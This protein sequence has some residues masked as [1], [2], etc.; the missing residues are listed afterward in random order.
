MERLTDLEVE[1]ISSAAVKLA[2]PPA[3]SGAGPVIE[4]GCLVGRSNIRG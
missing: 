1:S 2:L 3:G 4:F